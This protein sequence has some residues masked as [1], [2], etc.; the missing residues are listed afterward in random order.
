MTL[1]APANK[2][3]SQSFLVSTLR[4]LCSQERLK[5][6]IATLDILNQQA[7]LVPPRILSSLLDLAAKSR[8]VEHV[9]KVHSQIVANCPGSY[10]LLSTKLINAYGK[11]GSVHDA[12]K[13]FDQIPR[14]DIRSYNAMLHGYSRNRLFEDVI[15][16]F[17]HLE[18]TDLRPDGFTYPRVLKAFGALSKVSEGKRIHSKL[19]KSGFGS[20]QA[21]QNALISMYSRCSSLD[22]ARQVFS[23][24][25]QRNVVSWNSLIAGYE[26]NSLWDEALC[27]FLDMLNGDAVP[28][29][30][31][32]VSVLAACTA[33]GD[34]KKG[35]WVHDYLSSLGFSDDDILVNNSLIAL[36]AKCNQMVI[37][38]QLFSKVRERDVFTWTSMISG[39]AQAGADEAALLFF[40]QMH[41][42]GVRPN[43]V[44]F[45]SVLP[46]CA[47]LA[48]LK[49]GKLIHGL[50]ARLVSEFDDFA[51]CS[52]LDMYCKCGN[53]SDARELF[54]EIPKRALVSWNAMINGYGMHG[55]G[56]EA[57]ILFEQMEN[58]GIRPDHVTFVALLSACSHSGMIEAGMHYFD[59]VMN[60][61]RVPRRTEHYASIVDLLGRAGRLDDAWKLIE[62]MPIPVDADVWGALL[63]ACKIHGNINMGEYAAKKLFELKPQKAGYYVL[64]SNLYRATGKQNDVAKLKLLM[65]E[66]GVTK[67]SAYS[68]IEMGKDVHVFVACD[69]P[70]SNGICGIIKCL[71][72]HAEDERRKK[73]KECSE[74]SSSLH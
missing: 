55:Y 11:C 51:A 67:D 6:A 23:E 38:G 50:M 68:W 54:N 74:F 72:A 34:L 10:V 60:R 26:Q 36:Y 31:T 58:L 7:E 33:L 22:D 15:R 1:L 24:M 21:M 25:Q 8:S 41:V 46:V 61:Y 71:E 20:R 59:T 57:S 63:G 73:L 30:V 14:R 17:L 66:K 49:V 39:Y 28:D 18:G 52:L 56:K 29:S 13:V 37:A 3:A 70:E 44:T 16:L 53:L 9:S 5:E 45:T 42:A 40:Q 69:H 62:R 47:R 48:A 35:M 12:R 64:L 19:I 27:L 32:I 65:K 4:V 43:K 2:G